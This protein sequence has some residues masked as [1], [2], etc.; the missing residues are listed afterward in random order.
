LSNHAYER[1]IV[2]R[3][4]C[5]HDFQSTNAKSNYAWWWT[6]VDRWWWSGR[7]RFWGRAAGVGS[8]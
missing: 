4:S 5:L 6:T 8:S 3:R 2:I 7:G 1:E